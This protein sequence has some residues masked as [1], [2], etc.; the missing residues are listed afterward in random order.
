MYDFNCILKNE[1]TVCVCVC[2]CVCVR[3]R[4]CARVC[5]CVCV[6][7]KYVERERCGG[8]GDEFPPLELRKTSCKRWVI[9]HFHSKE[10]IKDWK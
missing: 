3:A 7:E 2:V 10:D 9:C 8:Q 6:C 5:V 4:V 1:R